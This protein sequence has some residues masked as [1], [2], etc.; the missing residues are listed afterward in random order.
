MVM[1][2]LM[3][4]N[5]NGFSLNK[6]GGI[7]SPFMEGQVGATAAALCPAIN[8]PKINC[9]NKITIMIE[10]KLFKNEYFIL[11]DVI[12][13]FKPTQNTSEINPKANTKCSASLVGATYM[14]SPESPLS[15]IIQPIAP[16]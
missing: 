9:T 14:A 11:T 13:H 10:V 3:K 8:E 4:F 15:T 1:V 12:N 2:L 6:P 7:A 5:I 16:C